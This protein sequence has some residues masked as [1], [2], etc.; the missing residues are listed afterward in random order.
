MY[1]SHWAWLE[2]QS[3]SS[4]LWS[5][6]RARIAITWMS[7]KGRTVALWCFSPRSCCHLRAF[8]S[9]IGNKWL[10]AGTCT[11][12]TLSPPHPHMNPARARP[13]LP[14][15]WHNGSQWNSGCIVNSISAPTRPCPGLMSISS[16]KEGS[17]CLIHTDTHRGNDWEYA[18][19]YF[20]LNYCVEQFW[21]TL[22]FVFK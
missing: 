4:C 22:A 21:K 20:C 15:I 19:L 16:Y 7:L 11:S 9:Q 6:D 12:P 2:W 10:R 17:V 5:S 14:F 18:L 13:L 3:D 1:Q 8:K